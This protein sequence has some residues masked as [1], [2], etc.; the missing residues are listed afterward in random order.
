MNAATNT[1]TEFRRHALVSAVERVV[2]NTPVLDIHTHLYDPA[3]GGLLLWGIDDLLTYHYLVAEAFQVHRLP[4][5]KFWLMT[6]VEQAELVWQ[7]LFLERS[8]VSEAARGVL[9]TLHRLGL[10]VKPRDLNLIRDWFQQ[11]PTEAY[12]TRCMEIANVES[13][14][15]TN[16]PFDD[17]EWPVWSQGFLRDDRF[18]AALRLDP[19]LM[20]WPRA[21]L[22]L[23]GWSYDVG[24]GLSARTISEVRRFLADATRRLEARYLMVSLP[25]DFGF[26]E[27]TDA[28]Q[29]LEQ[30][31][32]PHCEEF[33][34]PMALMLGVRRGVNPELR[35][36]GDGLGRS[37]LCALAN[38]CAAFPRNRFLATVLARENQHE[39][40]VLARKFPNLHVFGCWWFTN[41][42]L[43]I[44]EITRM[45]LEL[46]GLSFTPQHSDARVLDQIVYKWDHARKIVARVLVDKYADLITTGWEPSVNEIERDVR[47]LFG[48]AFNR[49]CKG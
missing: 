37:D 41:I 4:P 30:A 45:R 29:L 21:A 20:D 24:E 26:P 1:A 9:T 40:C 43:L 16:S 14:Y 3:L 42:P 23:A 17:A 2:S 7:T 46:L 34:L 27:N 38:L 25:P 8:P 36:A 35:L 47:E 13:I 39:L 44:E 10:D 19:L 18:I 28:A 5:E 12:I 31:V 6:K 49:F 22:R 48:G 15:M 11:W 33:G 32:L